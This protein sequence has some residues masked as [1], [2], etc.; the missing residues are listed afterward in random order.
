MAVIMIMNRCGEAAASV[1][2]G[3]KHALFDVLE[4][5]SDA[6]LGGDSCRC[7]HQIILLGLVVLAARVS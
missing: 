3:L 1:S 6:S 7:R 4:D 2:L 5:L